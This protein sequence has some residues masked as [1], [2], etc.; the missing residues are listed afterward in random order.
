[1]MGT[2]AKVIEKIKKRGE[3]DA[4]RDA[5][6]KCLWQIRQA[7]EK[8][9]VDDFKEYAT[10]VPKIDCLRSRANA[11]YTAIDWPERTPEPSDD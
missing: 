7:A 10:C 3:G 4:L 8:A 6:R 1:M 11:I 2:H 9:S 5:L